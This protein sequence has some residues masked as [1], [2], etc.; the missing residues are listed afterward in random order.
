MMV[1]CSRIMLNSNQD[2]SDASCSVDRRCSLGPLGGLAPSAAWTPT[3]RIFASSAPAGCPQPPNFPTGIEVYL[4]A[5]QNWTGEISID[6]LWT[7]TPCAPLGVVHL[8]NWARTAG[9]ALRPRGFKH[10]W[11]PLVVTPDTTCLNQV[12]LMD[13]TSGLSFMSMETD[14]TPSIRVGAGTSMG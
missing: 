14:G 7:C 4:Q 2:L 5:F 6:Q 12:V 8:M 3:H 1:L 11:S 10:N 13:M 9:Y